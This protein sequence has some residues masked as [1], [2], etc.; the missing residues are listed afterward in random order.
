M[1]MMKQELPRHAT[2]ERLAYLDQCFEWRGYANRSDLITKFGISATQAVFDFRKYFEWCRDPLPIYNSVSKAY[3]ASELH[4]GLP[5]FFDRPLTYSTI[6][7]GAGDRFERVPMVSR[8]CPPLVMRNLYQAMKRGRRVEVDYMS[9]E[10]GEFFRQWVAPARVASVGELIHFRGWS[11][12]DSEWCDIIPA[13]VAESSSFAAEPI[14]SLLPTDKQWETR[15]EIE[16]RLKSGLSDKQRRVAREGYGM[17][18][19]SLAIETNEALVS[20]LESRMGI[21]APDASIERHSVTRVV[22]EH[23]RLLE[24]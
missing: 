4:V 20:H 10:T 3:V 17:I 21:N 12:R 23:L 19:D 5:E 18:G 13:R 6:I 9:M 1:A 14:V 2:I 24:A 22:P 8:H 7:D 15:V 16:F 11:Y